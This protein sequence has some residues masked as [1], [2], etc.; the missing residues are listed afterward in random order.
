MG[1]KAFRTSIAWTRIFPNGDETEPNEEGLQFYDRL[2]DELRKHQIEPVVTISHYE[3]PLG[4]VKNY[5]GWRNRRTVDF[6][7]RYARTVFTRYKDKVKYWMTFN[8]INVVLHAP[9]TGGGIFREGENKQNTM[10]QAT[11]NLWRARWR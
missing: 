8:E 7:E 1:F 11:I 5:G 2:F 6:Y 9:F 3:M 10:Y 4:L